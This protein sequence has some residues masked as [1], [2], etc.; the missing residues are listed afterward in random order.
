VEEAAGPSRSAPT[1]G[2]AQH[3]DDDPGADLEGPRAFGPAGK[4]SA[5]KRRAR[6]VRPSSDPDDLE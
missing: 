4:R 1:E 3:V 2:A 5:K 6:P